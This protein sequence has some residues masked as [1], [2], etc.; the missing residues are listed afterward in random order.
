[1]WEGGVLGVEGGR[2]GLLGLGQLLIERLRRVVLEGERRLAN[3]NGGGFLAHLLAL[4]IPLEGVKEEA[5]MGHAV[6]IEDLLLLLG[7]DAVVLI[8]EVEK[9]ALG[10]FQRGIGTRLEISQIGEDTLLKL[11]RVLDRTAKGLESE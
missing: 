11:L 7:S 9:G 5:I 2:V 6:P 4:Q 8:E 3:A 1:M 10:L